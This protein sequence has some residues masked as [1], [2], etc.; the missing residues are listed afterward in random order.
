MLTTPAVFTII[1][2]LY[3]PTIATNFNPTQR[4]R[5]TSAGI[6]NAGIVGNHGFT[7]L[8]WRG[9]PIVSD[10]KCTSG[11]IFTLN[12]NYLDLYEATPDSNF[13]RTT[14]QGFGMT[15]WKPSINQ[16]A[17]T[18]QLIWYGQLVGTQPRKHARRTG[19]TS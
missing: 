4:F 10:D 17:I 14:S 8:A 11:N 15:G 1:E 2:A 6:E 19:V 13:V 3:T 9:V 18:A 5:M 7:G 12:T 16:D